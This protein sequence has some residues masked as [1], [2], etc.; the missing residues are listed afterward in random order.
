MLGRLEK[1]S[2]V[3]V[4]YVKKSGECYGRWLRRKR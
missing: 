3:P 4:L 2:K 1:H